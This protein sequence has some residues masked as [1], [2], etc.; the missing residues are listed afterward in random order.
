MVN[1]WCVKMVYPMIGTRGILLNHALARGLFLPWPSMFGSKKLVPLSRRYKGNPNEGTSCCMLLWIGQNKTPTFP[2]V[3]PWGFPP[4]F[5]PSNHTRGAFF[6]GDAAAAAAV[7]T[8]HSTTCSTVTIGQCLVATRRCLGKPA[9]PKRKPTSSHPVP[10]RQGAKPTAVPS[11]T[12]RWWLQSLRHA[13]AL[14][15]NLPELED[16]AVHGHPSADPEHTTLDVFSPSKSEW[17]VRLFETTTRGNKD[18]FQIS[19]F[20]V[21]ISFEFNQFWGS[22]KLTALIHCWGTNLK[23][24]AFFTLIL[25]NSK[26]GVPP[27]EYVPSLSNTHGRYCSNKS[28]GSHV[29]SICR[30]LLAPFPDLLSGLDCAAMRADRWCN[31]VYAHV[32]PDHNGL[33][34]ATTA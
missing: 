17:R 28:C 7:A 18:L 6:T 11:R 26:A 29:W 2:H 30:Y 23:C 15:W 10:L 19:G 22:L 16:D 33:K 8:W 1:I 27:F 4:N 34:L 9:A 31:I 5:R 20:P 14:P 32:Q 21:N 24:A 3:F 12:P 25:Q 13:E